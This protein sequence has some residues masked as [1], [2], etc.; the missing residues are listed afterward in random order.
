MISTKGRYALRVMIDLAQQDPDRYIPLAEIAERQQISKKYLEI[1]VNTLV[2]SGL[3]EGLRGKGGGYKL[4]RAPQDYTVGEILEPAEGSL[5]VVACLQN[6]APAC[7][8]SHSCN[9]LPLWERLDDMIRGYLA[10]VTLKDLME[11]NYSAGNSGVE[12]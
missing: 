9:T 10:S 11:G 2:K 5:A 12:R 8:R 1:I 4:T 3:L 7:V 6:G